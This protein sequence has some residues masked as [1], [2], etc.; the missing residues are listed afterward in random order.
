MQRARCVFVRC[1]QSIISGKWRTSVWIT[2]AC[3][4]MF[5]NAVYR[6]IISPANQIESQNKNVNRSSHRPRLFTEKCVCIRLSIG[7][8]NQHRPTVKQIL[9]RSPRDRVTN[10]TPQFLLAIDYDSV[11][12]PLYRLHRRDNRRKYSEFSLHCHE[13]NFYRLT[14]Y[15]LG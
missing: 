6:I 3:G 14:V 7:I 12:V 2:A 15:R 10:R 9:S 5:V 11:F 13:R 4:P 8:L 1:S